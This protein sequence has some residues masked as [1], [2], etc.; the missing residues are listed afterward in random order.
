MLLAGSSGNNTDLRSYRNRASFCIKRTDGPDVVAAE[1]IQRV[2]EQL[3][4]CTT[5]DTR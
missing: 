3:N 5:A 1:G 4:K 2:T